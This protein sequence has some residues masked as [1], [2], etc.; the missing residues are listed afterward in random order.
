MDGGGYH[1]KLP[2][3]LQTLAARVLAAA[4]VYRALCEDRPYRAALDPK[5]AAVELRREAAQG[6]LDPQAAE[7]VLAAAGHRARP[8]RAPL[9]DLSARELEVLRLLVRG[10]SNRE[11]G[12]R[13]FISP[14]TVGHHVQHIYGKL[15]ISTRA[16]AALYAAQNNLLDQEG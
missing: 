16:G 12:K 5:A 3:S 2:A 15:D 4:D 9:A 13:L 6:R 11:M 8:A 14:K 1:R 7:A 10:L